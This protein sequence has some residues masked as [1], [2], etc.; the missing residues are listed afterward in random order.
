MRTLTFSTLFPNSERPSHGIFVATRLRHLLESGRVQTR[1]VAPVPWFPSASARFG[2]YGSYAR[3]PREEAYHGVRV[4]H[5]RYCVLPK[6]GMN[7]APLLLAIAARSTLSRMQRDGYDF[8]LIDS[9]YFYPDGVAAAILGRSLNKP[10]LITARGTD[11]TLIPKYRLPR[12]MIRWAA[13]QAA[14]IITV[15]ASLKAALVELGVAPEKIQVLR[16]GVDLRL[17]HPVERSAIRS[18]LGLNGPTLLSVGHLIERKGHDLAIRA[19]TRLPDFELLIAG[20]GPE[21][22]HLKALASESGVGTRVR[23]LGSLTQLQLRDFYG[24]ADALVLASSREGWANVL[25][26]AMACGTP[27]VATAVDG[28]PEVVARPEAG[29]LVQERTPDALAAAVR[30]LFSRYPDHAATRRYAEQFSWDETTKGQLDLF[31]RVAGPGES[32]SLR[33]A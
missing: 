18:S 27:V 6:I 9:H 13:H 5:P 12:R 20:D 19:L 32:A 10:V 8:D 25:L 21:E 16:N 26:E 11:V 28:T 7:A 2:P 3:V 24:A 14:G 22:Q 15:S 23:F 1:V 4:L 30:Q 29:V 17:F 33:T 31:E